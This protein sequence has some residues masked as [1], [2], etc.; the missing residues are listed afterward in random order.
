MAFDL[1]TLDRPFLSLSSNLGFSI[2]SDT[3]REPQLEENSGPMRIII[4][5]AS[6]QLGTY[7]I[8]LLQQS[9]DFVIPWNGPTSSTSSPNAR[10]LDLTDSQ[11]VH[12]ALNQDRPEGIIHLAAVSR[13]A[14]AFRDPLMAQ[15]LNIDATAQ[16]A[17]WSFHHQTRLILASTD[18]VFDGS[19]GWRSESDPAEPVLEYGRTKLKAEESLYRDGD[20]LAARLSLLYGP[21]ASGRPTFFDALKTALSKGESRSFF[22]DEWRT[23][24]DYATAGLL[25]IQL[26]K[27]R[28]INGV[29][30]LGGQERLNRFQLA[31]RFAEAMDRDPALIQPNRQ[32]DVPSPEPRPADVSLRTDLLSER[33]PGLVPES[34]ESGLERSLAVIRDQ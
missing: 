12:E 2:G 21:S 22:G 6:G 30:H 18:L 9:D 4:T 24:L 14:D 23:P 5:G 3:L 16:L 13:V 8:R 20:Q 29:I 10:S 19:L 7:L 1:R 31:Q 32:A 17:E 26:V 28:E 11:A 34:I 33:L 15:R 25:L 27:R